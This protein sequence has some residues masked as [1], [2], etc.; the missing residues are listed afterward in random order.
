MRNPMKAFV[1][2]TTDKPASVISVVRIDPAD[3]A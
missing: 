3:G 1:L 2:E